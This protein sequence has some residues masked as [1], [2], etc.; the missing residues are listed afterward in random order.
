[1]SDVHFVNTVLHGNC[2][3]GVTSTNKKGTYGLRE[4]WLNSQGIA[5]FLSIPQL[6]RDGYE[7]NYN[8]KHEWVVITPSVELIVF[9]R[10]TG[11]CAGMP[12][13][14]EV[15]QPSGCFLALCLTLVRIVGL[16]LNVA[17]DQLR[18]SYL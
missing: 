3:A 2:N 9:K 5:N 11:V 10:N 13:M 17:L 18:W 6:E 12:Y 16:F 14:L 1:M 8:T 15:S 4:F 7:I